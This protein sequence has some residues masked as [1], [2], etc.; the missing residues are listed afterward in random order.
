VS[1]VFG[2]ELFNRSPGHLIL[3]SLRMVDDV[4]YLRAQSVFCLTL[5]REMSDR[6]AAERL[7]Q[8]AAD[9]TLRA[10]RLEEREQR[11]NREAAVRE[12][13]SLPNETKKR[14]TL[15]CRAPT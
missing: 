4:A 13:K 2:N 9:Y 12:Y 6:K 5:A 7:K 10:K 11:H 14:D 1:R 8:E 3:K 15:R